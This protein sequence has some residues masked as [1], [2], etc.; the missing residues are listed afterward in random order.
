MKRTVVNASL[1]V[2]LVACLEGCV[3]LNKSYPI[4]STPSGIRIEP[5]ARSEYKVL[6][7]TEGTACVKYVLGG[8]TPWFSGAP[9]KSVSRIGDKKMFSGSFMVS[10]PIVG[11]FFGGEEQLIDIAMYEALDKV[12]GADALMSIRVSMHRRFKF[13]LFF[14]EECVTIKGKAFQIKTDKPD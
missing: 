5:L 1:L 12:P 7:D 3:T 2:A 13:P 8:R 10:I 9:E 11:S 6:G 4:N 14:C